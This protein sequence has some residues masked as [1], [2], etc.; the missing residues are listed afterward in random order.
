MAS[1][2]EPSEPP[3]PYTP[4]NA[5]SSASTSQSQSQPQSQDLSRLQVPHRI[6]NGIPIEARRSMEDEARELPPNWVRSYDPE[7]HHQFFVDTSEDPPRSIWHHPYDDEQYMSTLSESER[8][9]IQSLH[10]IPSEADMRHESSDDD[11]GPSH[12][13]M[14]GAG[15]QLPPR[16]NPVDQP[17]GVSKL[18]RKMKDKLTSSTHEEREIERRHREEEEQKAYERHQA[19]RRAM[20]RA[21][22]TGQPQLIGKDREGK[23]VY[24][25]PPPPPQMGGMYGGGLGGYPGRGGY[26]M[27]G[28]GYSP[29]ST[30]MYCTPNAR[31]M[32]PSGPYGRPY[33]GGYGGGFGLPLL[34]LG[35][36]MMLGG[37]LF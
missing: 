6:R 10:R 2:S 34:G 36:G 18:G 11:S 12:N 13:R 29:Y 28:Y 17:K 37:M 7:T 15:G 20:S 14:G 1:T 8:A 19:I 27:G 9:R 5:S 23:D 22:Q 32:R 31:Y 21:M 16:P 4:N 3:P 33:G 35:S 24:I 26:G 30:G 25:E